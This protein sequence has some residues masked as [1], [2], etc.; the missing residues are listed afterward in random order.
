MRISYGRS[1]VLA[2]VLLC[3]PGLNAALAQS[4]PQSKDPSGSQAG[5]SGKTRPDNMGSEGS[6]ESQLKK[7]DA[8][9]PKSDSK[10]ETK[11]KAKKVTPRKSS[12]STTKS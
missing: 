10:K 3:G 8:D 9:T 1:L 4:Q 6:S 2:L 7:C 11:R 5:S 12:A